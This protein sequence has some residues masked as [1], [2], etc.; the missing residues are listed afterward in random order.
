MLVVAAVIER[1]GLFLL[2]RR[3]A[4]K[5]DPGCWEF[6]GGKVEHGESPQAALI[7]ELMEEMDVEIQVG[8]VVHETPRFQAYRARI[9]HGEPRLK[10]HDELVWVAPGGFDAY[11][12]HL[13][14]QEVAARLGKPSS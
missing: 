3:A 4:H 9:S 14:D 5:S 1:E 10:D 11:P 12:M 7:R 8:V 13:F 6:P 2:A